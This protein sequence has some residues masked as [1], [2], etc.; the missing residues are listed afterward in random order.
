MRLYNHLQPK[1][2]KKIIELANQKQTQYKINKITG[3]SKGKIKRCL[4]FAK[5]TEIIQNTWQ[6]WKGPYKRVSYNFKKWVDQR[7]SSKAMRAYDYAQH[8]QMVYAFFISFCKELYEKKILGVKVRRSA[9]EYIKEFKRLHPTK[10]F[11][12]R[13]W[14]YKM[15]KSNHYDFN[16]NWLVH[17]KPKKFKFK[18]E[19]EQLKPMK[20]NSIELRPPKAELVIGEDNLEIDSVIGKRD[21]KTAILTLMNYCNGKRYARKYDRTMKGFCAALKYLIRKHKIK[22]NTLTMDNGGENNLLGTII[23][24]HKLFNCHPYCSGEKGTLENSHRLI[25]RII[26][27]GKSMDDYTN[28]DIEV[29][30]TFCNNY[31]SKRFNQ[32]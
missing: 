31:Y 30:M 12:K 16:I 11:P 18:S 32:L 15:A 17:T 14:L 7:D 23:E 13:D 5:V 25:R 24:P 1:D 22:I 28:K 4:D 8:A 19:E 21:D 2:A 29:L 20:F 6:P 10:D 26:P 3:I 9:D 27:K